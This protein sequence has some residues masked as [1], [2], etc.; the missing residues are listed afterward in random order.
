MKNLYARY[1]TYAFRVGILAICALPIIL[2]LTYINFIDLE[3]IVV[4]GLSAVFSLGSSIYF[5]RVSQQLPEYTSALSNKDFSINEFN[6]QPDASLYSRM[7]L[8]SHEGQQQYVIEPT[9]RK[10][11]SRYLTF[12]SIISSGWVI[13]I[14][15]D[16]MTLDRSRVFSFIVKNEWKQF[17]ITILNEKDEV[18]AF[19]KQPWLKSALKN[20]GV[21]FLPF[22]DEWRII[23]AKNIS[24]DIDIR[25][26]DNRLMASYRYG[27][28]PYTLHP[29]FQALP[30]NIH[31]KLGSHVLEDERKAY[32]AIFYF[33]LN[34]K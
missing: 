2:Y 17:R 8:V 6:F 11:F 25:D 5:K 13:P 24:G 27:M 14:T 34:G 3:P 10:P 18:I 4:V 33:W 28:F 16:V 7:Y 15:Y 1:S 29:A 31:I 26:N 19:Y 23:E 9:I 20:N 30:I 32:L 12:F 22:Q 21:L